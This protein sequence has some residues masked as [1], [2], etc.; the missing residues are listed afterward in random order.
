MVWIFYG[1]LAKFENIR[2]DNLFHVGVI[3]SLKIFKYKTWSDTIYYAFSKRVLIFS[4]KEI[5][6]T[7]FSAQQYSVNISEHVSR[8][9]QTT[10]M[11]VAKEAENPLLCKIICNSYLFIGDT[12]WFTVPD[13]VVTPQILSALSYCISHSEK[14][15]IL[16]CKTL[17]NEGASILLQHLTCNIENCDHKTCHHSNCIRMLN[18]FSNPEQIDGLVKIIH[19]QNSLEYIILSQSIS[20]DDSCIVKL[21]EALCHNTCVRMLHL[22]GCNLT[23]VGIAALANTL[24]YN[25]T[26]EW[27]GLRDNRDTLKEEDIILLMDSIYHHNN[28]LYMLALDSIFHESPAVQLYIQKINNKRQHDNKQE[29]SVTMIDCIQFGSIC[30]HLLTIL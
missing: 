20:C 9:F 17:D 25:S 14:K 21:A 23:A 15:W 24:K 3:K 4:V 7:Y 10:L 12:C 18:V 13:C 11:A 27:I 8:E 28:T 30:R 29:L 22:L 26:I 5:L 2:F 1:G 16:Y 6:A 19:H